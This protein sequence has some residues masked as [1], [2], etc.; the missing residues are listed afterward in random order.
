[1][2]LM[3]S[4][5]ANQTSTA[6]G[7][8][9]AYAKAFAEGMAG[10]GDLNKDTKVTL[11]EIQSYSKK[12]TAELLAAARS[13]NK[14]DSIVAWSPSISKET[15]L[16]FTGKAVT[17]TSPK[18]LPKEP[19]LRWVGTETLPGFGKLSFAMYSNGRVVMVDAK[20]TTEG[21]W[22]KEENQLHAF[23]CQRLHRL[24]RHAQRRHAVRHG[25]QSVRTPGRHE[26]VDLDRQAT[27][28]LTRRMFTRRSRVRQRFTQI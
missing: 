17:E 1:M 15:P 25:N 7:N 6:L 20:S 12:R 4:S 18:L 5:A 24:H 28:R 22:R 11:G 14:Q 21:I 13:S 10:A 19:P 16:A 3:L 27:G 9:S 8:Y 2:I 26:V 23:V